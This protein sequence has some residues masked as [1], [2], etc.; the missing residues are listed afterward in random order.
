[1]KTYL[2]LMLLVLSLALAG[3]PKDDAATDGPANTTTTSGA[4]PSGAGMADPADK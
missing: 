2:V 1:M 3:C 4:D